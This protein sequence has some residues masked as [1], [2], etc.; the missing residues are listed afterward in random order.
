MC[1]VC[2][3]VWERQRQTLTLIWCNVFKVHHVK[4]CISTLF[5]FMTKL[6]S[7]IQI[8]HIDGH[9]ALHLLAIMSSSVMLICI[10][11][12]YGRVFRFSWVYTL[13]WSAGSHV[14]SMF[15]HL[16]NCP[17]QTDQCLFR[18]AFLPPLDIIWLFGHNHRR[19]CEVGYHYTFVLSFIMSDLFS[20]TSWAM[21]HFGNTLIFCFL[22][23]K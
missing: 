6:Y 4:S 14:N 5:L 2:V 7:I 19:E 15:N 12:L 18:F 17:E 8:E 1:C 23:I 3:C 13:E 16:R 22:S 11:V 21:W 9:L 10:H 20:C